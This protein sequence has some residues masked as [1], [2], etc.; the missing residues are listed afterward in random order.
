MGQFYWPK[1]GQN[2]WPLTK[3]LLR[4]AETEFAPKRSL[5]PVHFARIT[6]VQKPPKNEEIE[7]RTLYYVA[8]SGKPK[9]SL[10]QCPCGCGSVVTLSL[11]AVHTPQWRLT[12]SVS[13]HPTL[14][15]SVWRDKGCLS[16]FW[17]KEGRVFWCPDTGTHPDLRRFN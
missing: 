8:P 6:S 9:W 5:P 16:H 4:S 12:K 17:V 1:V 14:H 7:E 11:Q 10:F 2:R 13:G 3:G 15:P